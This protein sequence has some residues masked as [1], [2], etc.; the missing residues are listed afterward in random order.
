MIYN[1]YKNKN[2]NKKI[3][4]QFSPSGN[5]RVQQYSGTTRKLLQQRYT[6][7]QCTRIIR[8]ITTG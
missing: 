2:K 1:N 8:W 4:E 3:E 7:A 5:K 6:Y